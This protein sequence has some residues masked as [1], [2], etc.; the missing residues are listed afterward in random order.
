MGS[1]LMFVRCALLQ[2]LGKGEIVFAF[3]NVLG[4]GEKKSSLIG[5]FVPLVPSMPQGVRAL[6]ITNTTVTL[7]WKSPESPNGIILGYRVYF[8]RN[9]NFTDVVTVRRTES[10]MEH[11]LSDLRKCFLLVLC[12]WSAIF[13]HCPR[14]WDSGSDSS[15]NVKAWGL[16]KKHT[17][18]RAKDRESGRRWQ[19]R[20]AMAIK[21]TNGYEIYV[22]ELISSS[23]FKMGETK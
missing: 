22:A 3:Q 17:I 23:Q 10:R 9:N 5:S 12:F 8:M 4:A 20:L 19:S 6:N 14:N 1:K 21:H 11:V 2:I 16:S 15:Q 18:P 7:Q 13:W